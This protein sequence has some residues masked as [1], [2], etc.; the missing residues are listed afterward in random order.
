MRSYESFCERSVKYGVPWG[1][2]F[3]LL[4]L[5]A[6]TA[7]PPAAGYTLQSLTRLHGQKIIPVNKRKLHLCL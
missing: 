1:P 6:F 4:L 3:T 5:A 7:N 2:G